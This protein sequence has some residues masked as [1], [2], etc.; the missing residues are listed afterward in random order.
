MQPPTPADPWLGVALDGRFRILRQLGVGGM[1]GV[2]L[3][4]QLDVGRQVVVK[5]ILGDLARDPEMT[6]RFRREVLVLARLRHPNVVQVY[7]SG[8]APDGSLWVA[9]EYVPGRTLAEELMRCGALPEARALRIAEQVAGALAAAHAAGVVHRDL[10]PANVMLAD[11]PG[12]PDHVA[13][14]D[15]G[16]AKLAVVPSSDSSLTR[17]GSL[18]GTP[19]YMSP[20]QIQGL[21]DVDGRADVYALGVILYEM[22]AG[23]NPFVGPS[24]AECF[25]RHLQ[26]MPA[27]LRS[28]P[29]M[30][31]LSP[32]LESVIARCLEKPRERRFASAEELQA[33]LRATASPTLTAVAHPPTVALRGPGGTSKTLAFVLGLVA[34]GIAAALV[35]TLALQGGDEDPTLRPDATLVRA[36]EA[37]TLRPPAPEPLEARAAPEP[38]PG[39]TGP[40]PLAVPGPDGATVAR[41]VETP[42]DVPAEASGGDPADVDAEAAPAD[43]E[44]AEA[45]AEP[46]DA[47]AADVGEPL[48]PHPVLVDDGVFGEPIPVGA[49]LMQRMETLARYRVDYPWEQVGQA[50]QDRFRRERVMMGWHRDMNPPYF[51]VMPP[52]NVASFDSLRVE[53]GEHGHGATIAVISN[54]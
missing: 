28:V 38:S 9:M 50:Y 36:P 14:L 21:G 52:R 24:A 41:D 31:G 51:G 10:K 5:V 4:E 27:P 46:A 19:A 47:P 34:A 1:G 2:Y 16:I 25:V 23:R 32:T 18:V 45:A 26:S 40:L 17:A 37:G 22:L 6:E 13:V 3:A 20:E 8:Q 30:A 42:A 39:R 11:L 7:A 15:F 49:L 53:P 44:P 54:R 29:G 35:T 33:V 43:A 48:P 12:S